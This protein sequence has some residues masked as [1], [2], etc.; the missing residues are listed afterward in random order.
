[1]NKKG[2]PPEGV[3]RLGGGVQRGKNWNCNSIVKKKR[4][5]LFFDTSA[6]LNF[7]KIVMEKKSF[8]NCK[9][10]WKCLFPF[11]VIAYHSNMY[12]PATVPAVLRG[13]SVDPWCFW[14][15]LRVSL[16]ATLFAWQCEIAVCFFPLSRS[17][18]CTVV[19][20]TA[21]PSAVMANGGML[22]CFSKL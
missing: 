6:S 14:Y 19:S 16:E 22:V 11:I 9:A 17:H 10:P 8:V 4:T 12:W 15:T 20:E 18:D 3:G 5:K 7:P 21:W 2:G 13:W 1:M